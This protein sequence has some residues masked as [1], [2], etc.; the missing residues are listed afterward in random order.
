MSEATLKKKTAYKYN[1]MS[2]GTKTGFSLNGTHRSQGYIG[3]TSLSRSLPR[4][5]AKGTALKGYGGC[6]GKFHIGNSVISSISSTEDTKVVKNSVLDYEGMS[7]I[8]YQWKGRPAP[9][10]SV[11]PD[12]NQNN[13]SAGNYID[14][15]HQKTI[16]DI[17]NCGDNTK[18]C[19]SSTNSCNNI[20]SRKRTSMLFNFTKPQQGPNFISKSQSDYL[21]ELNKKCVDPY[22]NPSETQRI[23]F[24]CGFIPVDYCANN[25][26]NKAP[27][28][29][30][31]KI[32]NPAP[33]L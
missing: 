31:K 21:T 7:T 15:I 13:N 3:Q 24:A 25:S 12:N 17:N 14:Y 11:K 23:P 20:I 5:L 2:V 10:T 29:F 30:P 18:V 4:T 26:G 16:N 19:N 1:S 27:C 6:C 33:P 28:T 8:K 32:T 22:T 9:I